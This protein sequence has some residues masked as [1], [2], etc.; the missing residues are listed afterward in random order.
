MKF[1][2]IRIHRWQKRKK[3]WNG[4]NGTISSKRCHYCGT[5]KEEGK[6]FDVIRKY[7]PIAIK[8]IRGIIDAISVQVRTAWQRANTLRG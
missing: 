1:C 5:L 4:Q 6:L 7:V 8:K 2:K 3:Q